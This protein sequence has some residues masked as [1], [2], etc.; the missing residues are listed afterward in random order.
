VWIVTN[1]LAFDGSPDHVFLA[2]KSLVWC[3]VRV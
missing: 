3:V 2:F 1:R